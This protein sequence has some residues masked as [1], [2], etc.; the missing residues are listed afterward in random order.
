MSVGSA[1]KVTVKVKKKPRVFV[2]QSGMVIRRLTDLADVNVDAKEDGA[3]LIYDEQ[4][5]QFVTSRLLD[6]Q[7]IN[8]GHF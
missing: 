2:N 4:Q 3:L 1:G 6:K 8:G 5:E 7:E